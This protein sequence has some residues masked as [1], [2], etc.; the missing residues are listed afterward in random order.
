MEDMPDQLHNA[1]VNMRSSQIPA[2]A[3]RKKYVKYAVRGYLVC[4]S[5]HTTMRKAQLQSQE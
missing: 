1:A 5:E 3:K 2:W 4:A